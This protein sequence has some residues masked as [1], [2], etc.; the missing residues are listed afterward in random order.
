[1]ESYTEFNQ[2]EILNGIQNVEQNYQ[3]NNNQNQIQLQ[4]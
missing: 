1:M 2:E 4:K 3:K